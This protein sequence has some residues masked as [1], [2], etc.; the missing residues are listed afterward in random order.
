VSG[1]DAT[2]AGIATGFVVLGASIALG[3]L[4]GAEAGSL[5]R[6]VLALSAPVA[7]VLVG[8]VTGRTAR[9]RG[10]R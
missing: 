1:Y 8:V 5:A 9:E 10:D 4:V 2:R 6:L 3:A 7:A